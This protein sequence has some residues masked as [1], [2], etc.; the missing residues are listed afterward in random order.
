MYTHSNHQDLHNQRFANY[1]TW[2]GFRKGGLSD[3]GGVRY[4]LTTFVRNTEAE[5]ET[6]AVEKGDERAKIEVQK[7]N[8]L[9]AEALSF[10]DRG[11]LP[12][13][14]TRI[15]APLSCQRKRTPGLRL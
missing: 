12:A 3:R 14:H 8:R 5:P 15:S 10:G 7:L 1:V 13:L 9:L 11:V 6:I 2:F 4:F